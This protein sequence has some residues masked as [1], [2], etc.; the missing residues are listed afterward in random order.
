MIPIF[1]RASLE[2]SSWG[3]FLI[4]NS[5]IPDWAWMFLEGDSYIVAF[6][7]FT[8]LKNQLRVRSDY[9]QG[10]RSAQ[11][12]ERERNLFHRSRILGLIWSVIIVHNA[13]LIFRIRGASPAIFSCVRLN[14]LVTSSAPRPRPDLKIVW[15]RFQTFLCFD[16]FSLSVECLL[17]SALLE[18]IFLV[19]IK[20]LKLIPSLVEKDPGCF[21]VQWILIIDWLDNAKI[22]SD[23]LKILFS[24]PLDF[25]KWRCSNSPKGGLRWVIKYPIYH[26]FW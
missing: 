19:T 15:A 13:S 17:S 7:I 14:D 22:P 24:P 2:K 1:Y 3:D 10:S 21:Y 25:C 9:A 23:L 11:D 4:Q 8:C 12:L 5:S 6:Y 26:L 20:Y 16:S 18:F